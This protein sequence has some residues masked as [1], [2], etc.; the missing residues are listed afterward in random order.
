MLDFIFPPNLS[1]V[2]FYDLPCARLLQIS[3][4]Y[5]EVKSYRQSVTWTSATFGMRYITKSS[6]FYSHKAAA[7]VEQYFLSHESI[8]TTRL[9]C[10]LG[11]QLITL[12]Q[13]GSILFKT[14][15]GDFFTVSTVS[16]GMYLFSETNISLHFFKVN[17]GSSRLMRISLLRISSLQFFKTIT[18]IWLMRFYGL[19]ILLL[20][21]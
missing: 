10:S 11:A 7:S 18:K 21:T 8:I 14:E 20:R 5:Q 2:P 3:S 15:T 17:T 12:G 13:N 9:W 4:A 1:E 19:F 16:G 6:E